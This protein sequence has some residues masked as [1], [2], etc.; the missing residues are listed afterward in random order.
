MP[1]DLVGGQ[2]LL[3]SEGLGCSEEL[4]FMFWGRMDGVGEVENKFTSV[5]GVLI[6]SVVC[7][8]LQSVKKSKYFH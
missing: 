6:L 2:V 3:F 7:R 8:E 4:I 1:E 5:D